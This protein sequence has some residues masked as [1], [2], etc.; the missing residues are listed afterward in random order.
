VKEGSRKGAS[1][2]A[3]TLLGEPGRGAPFL[4]IRKDMGRRAQGMGITLLED[5][6]GEPGRELVYQG[7]VKAL[8]MGISLY[9]GPIENNGGGGLLTRNSER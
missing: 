5:P 9:R 6:A 1:V 4:G 8:E 3:E 7:L 2:S